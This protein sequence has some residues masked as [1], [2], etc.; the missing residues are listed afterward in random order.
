MSKT[1]VDL[2]ALAR[3]G[4]TTRLAAIQAERQAILRAFPELRGGEPTRARTSQ[5]EAPRRPGRTPMSQAARRA[6]S[7]RMKAYWAEKRRQQA[8]K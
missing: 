8:T 7:R 1:T 5:A 6:V 3:H 2:R 4:A